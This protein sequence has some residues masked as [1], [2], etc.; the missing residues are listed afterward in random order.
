MNL[1]LFEDFWAPR[2]PIILKNI[3]CVCDWGVTGMKVFRLQYTVSSL[4]L[5]SISH[6]FVWEN[7]EKI[8][9]VVG[10]SSVIVF[11]VLTLL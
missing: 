10:V 1:P 6:T 7:D 11:S 2:A 4:V 5:L 3:M 8:Y 9:C